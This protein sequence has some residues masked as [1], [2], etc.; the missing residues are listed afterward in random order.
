MSDWMNKNLDRQIEWIKNTNSNCSY[1]FVASL[2]HWSK[3]LP[4]VHLLM[5]SCSGLGRHSTAMKLVLGNNCIIPIL[6]SQCKAFYYFHILVEALFRLTMRAFAN[7]RATANIHVYM[8]FK[9]V[10]EIY[11]LKCVCWSCPFQTW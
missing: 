8:H 6:I 10:W 5:K 7:I 1:W 11:I 3:T 2:P 9:S 4:D